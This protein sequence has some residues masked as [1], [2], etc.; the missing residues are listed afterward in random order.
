M[1]TCMKRP[2]GSSDTSLGGGL[3]FI[4][5][6][7]GGPRRWRQV[8]REVQSSF[9]SRSSGA[10]GARRRMRG[11]EGWGRHLRNGAHPAATS[12]YALTHPSNLC[13][14]W[15]RLFAPRT[16]PDCSEWESAISPCGPSNRNGRRLGRVA[17]GPRSRCRPVTPYRVEEARQAAGQRDHARGSRTRRI[18]PAA[19]TS[20]QRMRRFPALVIRPR[21]S[22]SPELNSGERG[23]G[24][25]PPHAFGENVRRHRSW[26]QRPLRSP[27][28]RGEPSAGAGLARQS[29]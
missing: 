16:V 29:A 28:P 10:S 11:V 4:R 7:S 9:Y 18:G 5:P 3:S 12:T 27:V 25:P 21:R 14:T 1:S 2:P 26:P 8:S 20:H 22:L 6:L 15:M 17:H 19:W 24:R 23:H 13:E